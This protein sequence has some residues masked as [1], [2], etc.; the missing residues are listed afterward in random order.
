M[1]YGSQRQET[2]L[3]EAEFRI[4]EG[5]PSSSIKR[6]V[7]SRGGKINGDSLKGNFAVIKFQ[8]E[9]AENE[10]NLNEILVQYVDSPLTSK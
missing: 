9:S 2:N 5:N 3:V 7:N 1:T 6:D 10:I 4:L 8:K